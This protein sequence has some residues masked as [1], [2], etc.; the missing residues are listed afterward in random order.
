VDAHQVN[1]PAPV[2]G[3]LALPCLLLETLLAAASRRYAQE[4]ADDD[5][6]RARARMFVWRLERAYEESTDGKRAGEV[7]DSLR[8]IL[9]DLDVLGRAAVEW[10]SL[11]EVLAQEAERTYGR[12]PGLGAF[13][14]SQVKAVLVHVVLSNESLFPPHV[15]RILRTL[16]VEAVVSW[17]I[18]LVVE[19][20]NHDRG[21]WQAPPDSAPMAR[22]TLSKPL[23]WLLAFAA[24]LER[25]A[26][27][28]WLAR[29]LQAAVLRANPLSPALQ[30][31]LQQMS[32]NGVRS[33]RQTQE[34]LARL[35]AWVVEHRKELIGLIQLVSVSV[36]EADALLEMS[37]P[38]K[39]QYVREL[40]LVFLEQTGLIH[41]RVSGVIAS[42]M[43][44]WGIEFVLVVLRK[45]DKV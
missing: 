26:I 14:A 24:W 25:L 36:R 29:R 30:A 38:E 15:P 27:G 33:G 44:D 43:I 37:G 41:N 23:A 3:I 18:D 5:E 28:D 21:L 34:S 40:V 1:A 31:A 7:F 2:S 20:L 19:L 10:L 39:K 22:V 4:D 35:V 16:W 11:V 6:V 45:R 9:P 12:H 13:K 8:Q 42:W 32:D 17:A